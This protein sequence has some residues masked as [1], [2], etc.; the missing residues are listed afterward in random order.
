MKEGPR[1]VLAGENAA[2]RFDSRIEEKNGHKSVVIDVVAESGEVI[3]SGIPLHSLHRLEHFT[4]EVYD[5]R[6]VQLFG[7]MK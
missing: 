4:T 3:A 1:I 5:W 2:V 7:V 6:R